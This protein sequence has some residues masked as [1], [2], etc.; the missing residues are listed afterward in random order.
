MACKKSIIKVR[1]GLLLSCEGCEKSIDNPKNQFGH[2]AY[3]GDANYAYD[4]HKA[5]IAGKPAPNLHDDSGKRIKKY[6]I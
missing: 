6:D 1:G 2:Y 5:E 3:R 4:V